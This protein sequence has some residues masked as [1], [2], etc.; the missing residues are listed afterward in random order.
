MIT[1][2]LPTYEEAENLRRLLPELLAALDL[3][4]IEAEVVVVDDASTDGSAE[5]AEGLLGARGRVVRR[6]GRPGLARAAID[7]IRNARGDVLVLMDADLEHPVDLVVPLARTVLDG[8]AEVAVGSRF[9]PG[10]GIAGRSAWRRACSRVGAW[11][12]RGPAR[13][14]LDPLSGLLAFRRSVVEG[15]SLGTR[16]FKIGLEV[17]ARGRYAMAVEIPYVH[18][19]RVAGR[20]KFGVRASLAFLLQIASLRF[21]R[22]TESA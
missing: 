3:A 6:T 1:V 22:R 20:S 4:S 14:I 15:V 2:V 19:Q 12:A 11:L 8:R 10:G 13:G 16:G 7:G 9:A 21:A 5:V 17:L 18:G